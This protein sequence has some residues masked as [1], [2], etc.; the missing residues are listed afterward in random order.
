[1]KRTLALALL[2]PLLLSWNA[3]TR[4]QD[5]SRE[6]ETT[7][8][9][10]RL[11]TFWRRGIRNIF[12]VTD[13]GVIATD[14]ISPETAEVYRAEIAK[15][16]DQPV[17]YVIYS[18]EH[19]DHV[20]GGR[21][22]KDEG[23]EFISH[24]NCLKFFFRNPNPDLV[25]PDR[26]IS[27]N[28]RFSLG[29]E[30]FQLRYLGE[31]HGDC[32]LVFDF[33]EE[34]AIYLA[35]LATDGFI[36]LGTLPDYDIVEYLRSLREIEAMDFDLMIGAHGPARAGKDAVVIRRRWM[37]TIIEAVGSELDA[38]TP[39]GRNCRKVAFPRIRAPA[40]LQIAVAG[41]RAAHGPVPRDGLVAAGSGRGVRRARAAGSRDD[42]PRHRA[43]GGRCAG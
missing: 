19:W 34:R 25:I 35:D 21:I 8:I 27:G 43:V 39:V 20:L 32:L 22:F 41:L 7:K 1:M 3:E 4:A 38:G 10:D 17:R 9:S 23:A 24:E 11:Y 5:W 33:P 2:G 30:S 28:M 29:S 42:P 18:H 13:V 14:P 40:R 6:Y 36:G 12:V 37:E 15:V 26:T 31:N 16:T